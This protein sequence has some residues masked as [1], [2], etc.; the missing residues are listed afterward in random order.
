MAAAQNKKKRKTKKSR[1]H[2]KGARAPAL[3]CA[4]CGERDQ[5]PALLR[6]VITQE[7]GAVVDLRARIPGTALHLHPSAA[8]IGEFSEQPPNTESPPHAKATAEELRSAMETF[9]DRSILVELSRVAAAGQV[10]GG[11]DKLAAALRKGK[12]VCVLVA[13]DAARGSVD[14]LR[15]AA[16]PALPFH[17]LGVDKYDLGTQVGQAPRAAVG[18]P[19]SRAA[20]VLERWLGLRWRLA[21]SAS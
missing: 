2:R 20:A 8:C 12:I 21:G 14:S 13:C 4:G 1:G 19:S 9:L 5:S 10:V 6:L 18:V 7:H 16:G 11:H 3:R 17:S 15:R